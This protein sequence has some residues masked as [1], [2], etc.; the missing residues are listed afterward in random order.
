MNHFLITYRFSKGSE[1]DWQ[2]KIA[3]FITALENDPELGSR[4]SYTCLKSKKGPEYYHLAVTQDDEAAKLLGQKV[5][6]KHY[7]EQTELVSGGAV[8]VTPLELVNSTH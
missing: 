4:I 5:F 1:S 8:T 6:F 3:R 7:T 2:Q